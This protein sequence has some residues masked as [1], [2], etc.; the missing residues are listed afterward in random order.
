MVGQRKV[1]SSDK[2]L[3][4]AA[5]CHFGI[6][7]R[8]VSPASSLQ[9]GKGMHGERWVSVQHPSAISLS[10]F[11]PTRDRDP[12]AFSRDLPR[13]PSTSLTHSTHLPLHPRNQRVFPRPSLT[14]PDG[15]PARSKQSPIF[16]ISPPVRPPPRACLAHVGTPCRTTVARPLP[17]ASRARN[18][19][20][21]RRSQT[22]LNYRIWELSPV[23]LSS[24]LASNPSSASKP[25]L[26]DTVVGHDGMC[27]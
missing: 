19:R 22:I 1:W 25:F 7:F 21:L 9:G 26:F 15:N 20:W 14:K 17:G 2:K 8:L 12:T 10:L 16:S 5:T 27:Q 23:S 6:K 13:H 11:K 18:P 24:A 4:L 3:S